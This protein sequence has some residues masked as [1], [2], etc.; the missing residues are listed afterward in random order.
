LFVGAVPSTRP[1]KGQP[2]NGTPG[3]TETQVAR[4]VLRMWRALGFGEESAARGCVVSP[5]CGLAGADPD[6]VRTALALSRKAAAN[7]ADRP[8]A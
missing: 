1:A 3:P 6:W 5:V 4:S 8:E 7:L 2:A